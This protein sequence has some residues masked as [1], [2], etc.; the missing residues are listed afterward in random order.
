MQ[1][2]DEIS[3]V[4]ATTWVSRRPPVF[5]QAQFSTAAG[6]AAVAAVERHVRAGQPPGSVV[7]VTG[8]MLTPALRAARDR[9]AL[10]RLPMFS[11]ITPTG[12]PGTPGTQRP[13]T[14]SCGAPASAHP[15]TTS[16]PCIYETSAAISA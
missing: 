1:L 6:R 8:L 14:S 2:L 15:W 10:H 12:S 9:G 13:S 4:T 16:R 3:Q 11:R 7:S 5:S